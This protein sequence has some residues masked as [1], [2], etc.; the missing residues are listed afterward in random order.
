MR[1]LKVVLIFTLIA[2]L[3]LQ[4]AHAS[5]THPET[6]FTLHPPAADTDGI[7]RVLLYH[8]MEGLSGQDEWRTALF[9][10]K[11]LYPLA[12][13]YLINDINAVV[14]GLFAGG[15]DEVHV[16]DAHGSGN[17]DPDVQTDKLDPR[18]KQVFRDKPFRQYVDL[19]EPGVYDAIVVV[20]MHAKTGSN[21]FLAHTYT[22]GTD[23]IVNGLSITETELVA[24]SWGRVDVP[25]IFAS[26]DDRLR[27]DLETMP[28]IEYVEVK[29]ADNAH[30]IKKLVPVD[31]AHAQLRDKARRAVMRLDEMKAMKLTT[32][33]SAA[34]RVVPPAGLDIL[35]GVPG[36]NYKDNRVDFLADD[37]QAAYDG[38]VA[39]V[40]VTRSG[41]PDIAVEIMGQQTN[42]KEML[43]LY[44]ETLFLRWLEYEA[45]DWSPPEPEPETRTRF[46]GAQ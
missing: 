18:A 22:L 46:H 40:G 25:V 38:L 15:T 19:T 44:R 23:F 2:G 39:L 27:Q 36:V 28:W 10:N 11:D 42:G 21:G 33:V 34:L 9:A 30:T 3:T 32:P 5:D 45:G 37:F 26:G 7:L 4:T 41:R 1:V 12:Q 17:P 20:G 24:Y 8:D 43:D 35:D 16:V 13:E 14:D 29:Q 31:I 6:R